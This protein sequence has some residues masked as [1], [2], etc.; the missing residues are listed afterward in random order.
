MFD[1]KTKK[2]LKF[3]SVVEDLYVLLPEM[4]NESISKEVVISPGEKIKDRIDLI[5]DLKNCELIVSNE[6]QNKFEKPNF[7]K[8]LNAEVDD[9]INRYD[10]KRG[11]SFLIDKLKLSNLIKLQFSVTGKDE[12]VNKIISFIQSLSNKGYGIRIKLGE[13][14]VRDNFIYELSKNKILLEYFFN[15]FKKEVFGWSEKFSDADSFQYQLI[16]DFTNLILEDLLLVSSKKEILELISEVIKIRKKEPKQNFYYWQKLNSFIENNLS[17]II[18]ED[19]LF[20]KMEGIKFN[21]SS[22]LVDFIPENESN[23]YLEDVNQFKKKLFKFLKKGILFVSEENKFSTR[24][25]VISSK[26]NFSEFL[27]LLEFLPENYKFFISLENEFGLTPSFRKIEETSLKNLLF[28]KK[29]QKSN[30]IFFE[31]LDDAI[32]VLEIKKKHFN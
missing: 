19:W 22:F 11:N 27:K 2:E 13:I 21:W 16:A 6:N 3:N 15:F 18:K 7:I 30:K 10:Y 17:E 31:N 12:V 9:F 20:Y 14:K 24:S 23:E 28:L 26:E 1:T 4:I 8:V 5:L 32:T 25:N 29:V